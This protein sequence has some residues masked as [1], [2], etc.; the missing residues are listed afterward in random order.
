MNIHN[1][2]IDFDKKIEYYYNLIKNYIFNYWK[3]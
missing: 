2:I 3:I 1:K